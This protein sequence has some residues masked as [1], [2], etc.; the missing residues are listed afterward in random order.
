MITQSAIIKS[1]LKDIEPIQDQSL[2]SIIFGQH[3][4][5][6][7]GDNVGF[8]TWST[9]HHPVKNNLYPQVPNDM[10]MKELAQWLND[11][12]SLKA[13][14]GMAAY[15]ALLPL[16]ESPIW[17][18]IDVGE[19]CLKL[20]TNKNVVVVGHFPFVSSLRSH[21]ETL[22][23]L[24]KNPQEG[25]LNSEFAPLVLPKAD[26][27]IITATTLTNGTLGKI[28]QMC[29]KHCH[30]IIVGPST[31]LTLTLHEFGI[32][33]IAGAKVTDADLLKETIKKGVSF[34]HVQGVD[35]VIYAD[36]K[37]ELMM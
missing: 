23:V 11:P 35:F 36:E 32:N 13:S 10:T 33:L 7:E 14:V 20:A 30:K 8:A 31:P 29:S 22:T 18:S 1:L 27:V 9:P 21:F 6:A 37:K 3:L 28:L 24:E 2:K 26:L 16:P 34:K 17:E 19:L 4:V 25:D 5:A 12:D 15:K